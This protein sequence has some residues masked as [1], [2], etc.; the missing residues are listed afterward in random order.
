[1][2]WWIWLILAIFML[3]MIGAGIAYALIHGVRAMRS[4]SDTGT[5]ISALFARLDDPEQD[6]ATLQRPI[7]TEPLSVAADQY[8]DAHAVV[9]ERKAQRRRRY[10]AIWH[11]W[12]TF[13]E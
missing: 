12:V 3:I 8:T 2:P 5:Q 6:E 7:F 10:A 1:M 4:I 11:Q 9:L 13:N